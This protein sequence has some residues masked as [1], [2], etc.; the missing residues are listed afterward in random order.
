[1]V[2]CTGLQTV[3]GIKTILLFITVIWKLEKKSQK[4]SGKMERLNLKNHFFAVFPKS[5]FKFEYHDAS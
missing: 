4:K 1:M 5:F 2:P 3:R